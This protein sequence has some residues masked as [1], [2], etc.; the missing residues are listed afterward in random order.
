[1]FVGTGRSKKNLIECGKR[2]AGSRIV[3]FCNFLF[4]SEFHLFSVWVAGDDDNIL[5][6]GL[7]CPGDGTAD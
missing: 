6:V 4:C 5:P 7:Q 3:F 1:M 2:V